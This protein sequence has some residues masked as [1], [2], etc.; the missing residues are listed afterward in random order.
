MDDDFLLTKAEIAEV[1]VIDAPRPRRADNAY[2]VGRRRWG[3]AP[4]LR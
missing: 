2:G 1:R 4:G 3:I